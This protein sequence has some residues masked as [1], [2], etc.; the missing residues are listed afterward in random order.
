MRP[1]ELSAA[2]VGG[3]GGIN[4]TY[5]GSQQVHP[6]DHL[7]LRRNRQNSHQNYDQHRCI[8]KRP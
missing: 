8:D 1:I 7:A 5:L 4:G 2:C 3:R 6:R